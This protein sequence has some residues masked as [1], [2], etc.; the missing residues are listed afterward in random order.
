[1]KWSFSAHNT[2]RRCQRQ[3]YFGNI[4]ANHRARDK[5]RKEAYLL[6]QVKQ[7]SAWKGSIIHEGINKFVIPY[8]RE[9][10]RIDWPVALSNTLDLASKQYHFSKAHKFR[11][12]GITKSAYNGEYCILAEHERNQEI[13]DEILENI[14]DE[15]RTCF[16]NLSFQR[17]LISFFE[18][19]KSYYAEHF[20]SHS[21]DGV[22]IKA[23]PDLIFTG[24]Y[25]NTSVVDWKIEQDYSHGDHKLQVALY[26]WVL[27]NKWNISDPDKI[28][29][30]EA[31]L[32]EGNIIRH[33]FVPSMLEE[34]EDFIFQSITEIRSLCGD[35]KYE[36]QNLDDFQFAKSASTCAYCSF[37]RLCREVKRWEREPRHLIFLE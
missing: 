7:L 12:P 20:L 23:V 34:L 37:L 36:S 22:Q 3:Y 28:E 15:I 19:H 35:H 32:L 27:L 18:G 26:A 9:G 31:Q 5:I 21:F 25:G 33:D 8:L 11:Q 10:R 2:F 1:M 14:Y 16:N 24:I 4:A 6:K 30:Y 29:L 13:P 17:E